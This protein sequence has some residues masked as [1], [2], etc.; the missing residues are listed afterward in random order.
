[1]DITG[2]S[3]ALAGSK[4]PTELWIRRPVDNSRFTLE[5][6]RH[7]LRWRKD[8]GRNGLQADAAHASGIMFLGRLGRRSSTRLPS[9][10]GIFEILILIRFW[11]SCIGVQRFRRKLPGWHI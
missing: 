4:E 8:C 3:F 11:C 2:R 10:L 1:V 5:K 7:M 6:A 9:L